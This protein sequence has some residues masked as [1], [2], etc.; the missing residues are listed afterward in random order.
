MKNSGIRISLIYKGKNLQMVLEH[1]RKFSIS[2]YTDL[3][4]L[5]TLDFLIFHCHKIWLFWFHRLSTGQQGSECSV[6]AR[7]CV[8]SAL[9]EFCQPKQIFALIASDFVY[10]ES[11]RSVKA[12]ASR[13]KVE[14]LDITSKS[15][16]LSRRFELI[17]WAFGLYL[18]SFAETRSKNNSHIKR[19]DGKL[20]VSLSTF[21]CLTRPWLNSVSGWTN[22]AQQ[23]FGKILS[24]SWIKYFSHGRRP[25][26]WWSKAW[27]SSGFKF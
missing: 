10:A 3:N 9:F 6:C 22:P 1:K 13:G 25:C 11:L 5:N 26:E 17:N 14:I 27:R 12:N 24:N 20:F 16:L 4:S 18:L 21:C 7:C 15:Q 23:I 19:C 8:S 2:T